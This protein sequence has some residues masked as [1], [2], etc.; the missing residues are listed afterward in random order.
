MSAIDRSMDTVTRGA[1]TND[2]RRSRKEMAN[3]VRDVDA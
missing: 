1:A 3:L 2:H